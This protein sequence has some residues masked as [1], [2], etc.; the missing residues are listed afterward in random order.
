MAQDCTLASL[1]E[2]QGLECLW[3]SQGPRSPAQG[4]DDGRPSLR[5][6]ERLDSEG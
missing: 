3:D 4:V 2:Q 5:W 6:R 1:G